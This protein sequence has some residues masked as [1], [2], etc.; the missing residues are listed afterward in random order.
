MK[1]R[2]FLVAYAHQSGFGST[3]SITNGT[4]LNRYIF[5]EDTYKRDGLRIAIL[6]V[7][8]LSEGDASDFLGTTV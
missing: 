4:F 6:N 8:E 5:T 1:R 2:F 7:Q 3:I